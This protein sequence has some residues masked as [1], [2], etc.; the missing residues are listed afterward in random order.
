MSLNSKALTGLGLS[1]IMLAIVTPLCAAT[2]PEITSSVLSVTIAEKPFSLPV[3]LEVLVPDAGITQARLAVD[4]APILAD[5]V[6]LVRRT[7]RLPHDKCGLNVNVKDV[8]LSPVFGG[9]HV[10]VDVDW[11]VCALGMH[12]SGDSHLDANVFPVV[13][14]GRRVRFATRDGEASGELGHWFHGD[15]KKRIEDAAE[16]LPPIFDADG[17]VP[18]PLKSWLPSIK[19]SDVQLVQSEST[20]QIRALLTAK[21]PAAHP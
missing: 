19:V 4:L 5:R 3:S 1:A 7:L 13:D 17:I 21:S 9:T 16:R 8:S 6:D 10:R 14:D 20:W 18:N 12:Q 2:P 11:R 15:I